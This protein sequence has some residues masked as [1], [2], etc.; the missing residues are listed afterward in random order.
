MSEIP[1]KLYVWSDLGGDLQLV[2][3]MA[4][5]HAKLGRF[6]YARPFLQGPAPFA[7]NPLREPLRPEPFDYLTVPHMPGALLDAGPDDWGR[8]T[9]RS[10]GK[11]FDGLEPLALGSGTGVGSLLFSRSRDQRP[12]RMVAPPLDQIQNIADGV[13]RVEAGT[14]IPPHIALLLAAGTSMGGARPKATVAH[15][16]RTWL[17]K[18]PAM[19]DVVDQPAVEFATLSLARRCGLC[20]P[21]HALVDVGAQ[22]ALLVARFDIDERGHR[23][24][25]LSMASL[26]TTGQRIAER[27]LI[28]DQSYMGL[29]RALATLGGR[30]G[31]GDRVE[32]FRRAAFNLLIGHVDDHAR[33][34]GILLRSDDKQGYRLAPAFD[35]APSNGSLESITVLRP[36]QSI[37][38]GSE[39][40]HRSVANLLSQTKDFGLERSVAVAILDSLIEGIAG[41]REGFA[42]S[43][44]NEADIRMIERRICPPELLSPE[45]SPSHRGPRSP[46]APKLRP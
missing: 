9:L 23:H 33:N 26:L 39:G 4:S 45:E 42:A 40:A 44:V 29:S 32:L 37:G 16:G 24:H 5:S 41:W 6:Q 11:P 7:I 17:A 34:H 35:L 27:D 22:R 20:V 3:V 38:I 13:R 18:F 1:A 12:R 21:D 36:S 8:R 10:L 31:Q 19:N 2:G 15:Q 46:K 30:D 14:P 28:G 43:G 25:Y